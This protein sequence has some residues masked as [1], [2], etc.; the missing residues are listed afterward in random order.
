M[1]SKKFIA[2]A[3]IRRLMKREGAELVAENAVDVLVEKLVKIAKVVTEIAIIKRY[4][5]NRKVLS[6]D[7]IR[8]AAY[9]N[10]TRQPTKQ[11]M[12][13]YEKVVEK[14]AIIEAEKNKKLK[15]KR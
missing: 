8:S 11:L 2:H 7:D 10:D 4:E 6:A 14:K 15:K 3:P 1:S 5:D 9:F 12:E 13:K